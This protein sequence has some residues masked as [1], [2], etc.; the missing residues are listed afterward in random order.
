MIEEMQKEP[1]AE[2]R[3]DWRITCSGKLLS[4]DRGDDRMENYFSAIEKRFYMPW[5]ARST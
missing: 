1:A 4:S 3:R 5:Q 2:K